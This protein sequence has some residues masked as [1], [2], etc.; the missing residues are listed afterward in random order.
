MVGGETALAPLSSL[1]EFVVIDLDNQ[2]F[3][4]LEAAAQYAAARSDVLI[5]AGCSSAHNPR[6]PS[7]AADLMVQ[8][9]GRPPAAAQ[10][11]GHCPNAPTL[12][13][14]SGRLAP[15]AR[16]TALAS[17]ST[18]RTRVW[19]RRLDLL[20]WRARDGLEPASLEE[21]CLVKI[22]RPKIMLA[23]SLNTHRTARINQNLSHKSLSL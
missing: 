8:V 21:G 20:E 14:R 6:V 7:Q 19:S 11:S 10:P 17:S 13:S 4:A 3:V 22:I 12:C 15:R 9:A 23:H 5:L 1:R 18:V 16:P 2:A